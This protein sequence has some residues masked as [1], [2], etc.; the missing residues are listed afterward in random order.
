MYNSVRGNRATMF[1]NTMPLGTLASVPAL[2]RMCACVPSSLIAFFL[3]DLQQY[4][5]NYLVLCAF[6]VFVFFLSPHFSSSAGFIRYQNCC[7]VHSA[8]ALHFNCFVYNAH[9]SN[10][11]VERQC[12]CTLHEFYTYTPLDSIQ[13]YMLLS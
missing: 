13:Q 12:L 4:S 6:C 9:L 8:T 10:Y 11:A 3:R 7:P 2:V 5:S 1:T